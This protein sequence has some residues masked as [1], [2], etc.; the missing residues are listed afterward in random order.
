MRRRKY[1]KLYK[2]TDR[3]TRVKMYKAGKRWV[4]SLL[5]KIGLL[6]VA[7]DDVA[8][9]SVQV[10]SLEQK[11]AAAQ[12][13]LDKH[14]DLKKQALKS[15]L[16]AG[17][18]LGG[19]VVT[20]QVAK[21]DTTQDTEQNVS[22]QTSESKENST[23]SANS[24]TSTASTS[25]SVSTSSSTSESVAP[26]ESGKSS[27]ASESVSSSNQAST[28]ETTSQSESVASSESTT[29]ESSSVA[30]STTVSETATTSSQATPTPA[31]ATINSQDR[32]SVGSVSKGTVD[33]SGAPVYEDFNTWAGYDTSEFGPNKTISVVMTQ[34]A[35]NPNLKHYEITFLPDSRFYNS[36]GSRHYKMAS[37]RMGFALS[38][39][40]KIVGNIDFKTYYY[41]NNADHFSDGKTSDKKVLDKEFLINNGMV[42]DSKGNPIST[43]FY[44]NYGSWSSAWSQ[45]TKNENYQHNQSLLISNMKYASNSTDVHNHFFNDETGWDDTSPRVSY[46]GQR[47]A[48]GQSNGSGMFNDTIT[49][50]ATSNSSTK[51]QYNQNDFTQAYMWKSWGAWTNTQAGTYTVSFDAVS[52][53]T[54]KDEQTFSG[55]ITAFGTY[56]NASSYYY[57]HLTGEE[58]SKTREYKNITVQVK[59]EFD[60][61]G[62]EEVTMPERTVNIGYQK[63]T[64]KVDGANG[65]VYTVEDPY[66]QYKNINDTYVSTTVNDGQ[67]FTH[68]YS[69]NVIVPKAGN[70]TV[71]IDAN[72]TE[73]AKTADGKVLMADEYTQEDI[74]KDT[75]VTAPQI[76]GYTLTQT[77]SF[78]ASTGTLTVT[79]KY[80]RTVPLE[81]LSKEVTDYTN[82]VNN[83]LSYVTSDDFFNAWKYNPD[84]QTITPPQTS[85]AEYEET[86]KAKL[87]EIN[88]AAKTLRN[89][90]SALDPDNYEEYGYQYTSLLDMYTKVVAPFDSST[91]KQVKS[92]SPLYST[93]SQRDPKTNKMI[94]DWSDLPIDG[95]PAGNKYKDVLSTLISRTLRA[96]GSYRTTNSIIKGI[97]D[98]ISGAENIKNSTRYT[99][100]SPAK[101]AAFD[102]ALNNLKPQMT[103]VKNFK[104]LGDYYTLM[105]SQNKLKEAIYRLDHLTPEESLSNSASKSA[106]TSA[107]ESTST[108]ASESAS[109][110]ASE[111]AST[112]ASESASTSA[113]ETASTSAS[114][115]ASTSASES[116]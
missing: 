44:G 18:V 84:T 32:S 39:D 112:S 105:D 96:I 43:A 22:D 48:Q 115:S 16:T 65:K 54:I 2:E 111:S 41:L 87:A 86:Y 106:S 101:Q 3:K 60:T 33:L 11:R 104:N 40:L 27:V 45:A 52:D 110:S 78:D 37:A 88:E 34:D 90:I 63:I 6:R 56:Q 77:R 83:F 50:N 66:D 9:K 61:K 103:D 28:S 109:T 15:A 85:E 69:V 80:V 58:L 100:A 114:E 29:S 25:T 73:P 26:S 46:W 81:E 93:L 68:N 7:S 62:L 74:A 97:N 71:Y 1:N 8:D 19:A 5:S 47:E 108:S 12:E 14:S 38:K 94:I 72:Q 92:L 95:K 89:D 75:G 24:A 99:E 31:A 70:Q 55:V 57:G 51:G 76:K 53:P 49:M 82:K 17:T 67:S 42:Y 35:S 102:D 20:T 91:G 113:S 79:N 4:Q 23:V 98:L 21:A 10:N 107:S 36:S 30:P 13:S 116:A 64:N 59:D